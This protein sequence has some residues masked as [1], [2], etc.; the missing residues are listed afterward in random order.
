MKSLAVSMQMFGL[1]LLLIQ[2]QPKYIALLAMLA[3]DLVLID[4]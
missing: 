4:S 3:H 2:P 1:L